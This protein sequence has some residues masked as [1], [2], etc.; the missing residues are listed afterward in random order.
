MSMKYILTDYVAGAM[1]GAEYD[2]LADSTFAGKISSCP[3][4]VAFAPTLR[5]C[6]SELRSVLEEWLLVGLKLGHPIPTS[7]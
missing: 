3:G 2:K 1:A 7:E 6:E 4:V 5:E